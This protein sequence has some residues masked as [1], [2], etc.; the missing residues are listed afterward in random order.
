MQLGLLIAAGIIAAVVA[1]WTAI[2]HAWP[3]AL[4][5]LA[6]VLLALSLRA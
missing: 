6:V 2:D 5:A 4:L 3:I 1:I